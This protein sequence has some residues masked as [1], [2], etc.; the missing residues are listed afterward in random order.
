MVRTWGRSPQSEACHPPPWGVGLGLWDAWQSQAA[1][2][3]RETWVATHG[4]SQLGGSCNPWG[5]GCSSPSLS[6]SGMH[7]SFSTSGAGGCSC[8]APLGY[9]LMQ[10]PVLCECRVRLFLWEWCFV[11]LEVPGCSLGSLSCVVLAPSDH[12]HAAKPG[13][14]P[15]VWPTKPEPEN[16]APTCRGPMSC[17]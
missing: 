17:F 15:E 1:Q 5:Q 2:A 9:S 10:D 4:H 8:F 13:P 11:S 3:S 16:P 6:A 7:S 12:L 14:L